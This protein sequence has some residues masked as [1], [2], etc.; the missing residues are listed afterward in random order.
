MEEK[1]AAFRTTIIKRDEIAEKDKAKLEAQKAAVEKC[2][3]ALQGRVQAE[4]AELKGRLVTD[5]EQIVSGFEHQLEEQKRLARESEMRHAAELEEIRREI[6]E[7]E[8]EIV[9]KQQALELRAERIAG[10]EQSRRVTPEEFTAQM[11]AEEARIETRARNR[12]GRL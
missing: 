5:R 11:A 12:G 1:E 6:A 9:A 4:Q 10:I 7:Q 8:A 3:Q 2:L